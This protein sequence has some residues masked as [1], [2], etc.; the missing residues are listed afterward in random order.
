VENDRGPGGAGDPPIVVP[1]LRDYQQI[2]AELVRRL[3]LGQSHIRLEGVEG[4]RLL[5]S[6]IAGSWE[7][8][9][10]I[11]GDAGPELA[12]ELDCPRL[13]V[14]CRGSAADGAGSGLKAGKLVICQDGGPA[15]GY[16]QQGG[17]IVVL[18]DVGPRAGLNQNGG[19]LVLLGRSGALT[20]ERQTGGRLFLETDLTGPHLGFGARDGRRINLCG[21]EPLAQELDHDDRRLLAE[22]RNLAERFRPTS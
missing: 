22:V 13:L 11:K 16:F 12:V 17:L 20:G 10:E 3:D 21:A 7:A 9:V 1:E 6:R 5:A 2:N 15:V 14:V 19:D 18:G 8:V 4:Q